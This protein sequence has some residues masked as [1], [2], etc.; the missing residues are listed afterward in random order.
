MSPRRTYRVSAERTDRGWW[1]IRIL[2][3][4]HVVTQARRA[5]EIETMARDVIALLEDLPP[6]S[7]D[8]D[9]THR[10]GDDLGAGIAE[11]RRL[12]READDLTRRSRETTADV[13]RRLRSAGLS[14]REIGALLGIAH[15]RAQQILA[16]G[17]AAGR[18]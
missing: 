18:R 2:D 4:R 7:F 14:V 6:D 12:R 8:L 16:T 15:Q 1:V 5:A 10:V 3:F 11:A 9:V 13:A 17:D